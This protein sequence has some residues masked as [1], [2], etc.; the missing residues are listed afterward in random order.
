MPTFFRHIAVIESEHGK[1]LE[2]IHFIFLNNNNDSNDN[3][4]GSKKNM[5]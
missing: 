4:N 2:F 3:K 1:H 5:L